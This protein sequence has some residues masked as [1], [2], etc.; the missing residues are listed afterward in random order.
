MTRTQFKS[1]AVKL[2]LKAN[3]TATVGDWS[4]GPNR[5]TWANGKKGFSGRFAAT[6]PGFRARDIS[7]TFDGDGVWVR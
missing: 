1:K 2:F 7:A 5:V 6:A 3:P 4:F